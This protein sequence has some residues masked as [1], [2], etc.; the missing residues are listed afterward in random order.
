MIQLQKRIQWLDKI[1]RRSEAADGPL[2]GITRKSPIAV[3]ALQV[4]DDDDAITCNRCLARLRVL[5]VMTRN[6]GRR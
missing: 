3:Q 1:H 4:S 5:E 6:A 2:C